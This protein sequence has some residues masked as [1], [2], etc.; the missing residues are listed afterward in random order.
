MKQRNINFNET[1]LS[2]L[3]GRES[4]SEINIER[5]IKTY[6]NAF[7]HIENR[8]FSGGNIGKLSI[9]DIKI[10]GI[11]DASIGI[12]RPAQSIKAPLFVA[13]KLDLLSLSRLIIDIPH[14]SNDSGFDSKRLDGI[15]DISKE[16]SIIPRKNIIVE[17]TSHNPFSPYCFKGIFFRHHRF[18][19]GTAIRRYISWWDLCLSAADRSDEGAVCDAN[20]FS[21][22]FKNN[23]VSSSLVLR[24]IGAVID[25][26][27]KNDYINGFLF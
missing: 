25:D 23:Y 22:E 18:A 1:L 24:L 2:F 9:S 3:K 20:S 6:D 14:T 21:G 7:V 10:A 4:L 15:A 16:L 27:W 5:K 12:I 13:E 17:S 8:A 26:E 19:T 11:A